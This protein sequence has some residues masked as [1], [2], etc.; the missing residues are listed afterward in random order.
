MGITIAVMLISLLEWPKLKAKP[1]W[2]KAVFVSL[3]LLVWLLSMFD[4][5]NTTG[6][7]TVLQVIFNPF[8]ELVEP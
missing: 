4:L 7:S 2:D 6:P 5:P 1:M 3:L 8:K